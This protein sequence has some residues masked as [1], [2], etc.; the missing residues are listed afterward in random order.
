M[1]IYISWFLG[2]CGIIANALI[3]RRNNRKNLLYTKLASDIIWCLHYLLIS[4]FSGAVTCGIS[5]FRETVFLNRGKKWAD[6]KLWLILFFTCNLISIYFTWNGIFSIIPACASMTSI[7]IFWIGNPN[8]TRKCQIPISTAFLLYNATNH[9]YTGVINEILSLIS[10]FSMF[11]KNRKI[12][13][14]KK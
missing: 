14:T 3:Y 13:G 8:L 4:A 1:G 12:T 11:Y 5:I 7:V 2:A 6:S 10:I 9:S